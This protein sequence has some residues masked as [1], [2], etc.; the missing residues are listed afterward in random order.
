MGTVLAVDGFVIEIVKPD[1]KDLNRQEV[2]CYRNQKGV[3]ELIFQVACD[4][5]AKIRFVQTNWLGATNDLSCFRETA[6]FNLLKVISCLTGCILL[7]I[8]HTLRCL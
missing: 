6:L 1:A 4:A 7:R 8:K 3:W 2:S 5:N